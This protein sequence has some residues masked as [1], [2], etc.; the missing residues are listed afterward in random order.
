LG[1]SKIARLTTFGVLNE[2]QTLTASS[3][4]ERPI[5]GPDGSLWFVEF[6][7]NNLARITTAGVVTE[8]PIPTMN[9][10]PFD[11]TVGGDKN[12]WFTEIEGKVA[13]FV[14]PSP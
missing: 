4:P 9:A 12:V 7:G 8:Y 11:I 10:T 1:T 2:Y 5:T 14:P 13:R 3:T 6:S